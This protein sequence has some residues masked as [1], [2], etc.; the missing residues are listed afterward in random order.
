M[1]LKVWSTITYSRSTCQ[2]LCLLYSLPQ[3]LAQFQTRVETQKSVRPKNWEKDDPWSIN[4]VQRGTY[5]FYSVT[6]KEEQTKISHQISNWQL[7]HIYFGGEGG[8]YKSTLVIDHLMALFGQD[9]HHR[10][11]PCQIALRNSQSDFQKCGSE[12]PSHHNSPLHALR[13]KQGQVNNR[14]SA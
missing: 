14:F 3:N 11:T 10:E 5:E 12:F 8:E 1:F 13:W 9:S 7:F 6:A 2:E 4:S